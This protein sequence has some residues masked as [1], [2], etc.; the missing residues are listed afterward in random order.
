MVEGDK[1]Q[2]S[3]SCRLRIDECGGVGCREPGRW[4]SLTEQM[5]LGQGPGGKGGDSRTVSA[6]KAHSGLRLQGA[7]GAMGLP[8]TSWPSVLGKQGLQLGRGTAAAGFVDSAQ[9]GTRRLPLERQTA[10]ASGDPPSWVIICFWPG[11]VCPQE[12]SCYR[13]SSQK[14]GQGGEMCWLGPGP[15]G[16]PGWRG[17]GPVE[18]ETKGS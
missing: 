8:H 14:W 2:G 13:T 3:T 6:G 5:G 17:E 4:A 15:A 18:L 1:G 9:D 10:Q 7:A 11:A 12:L 16:T